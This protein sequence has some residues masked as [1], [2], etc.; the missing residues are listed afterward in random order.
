MS[1]IR[2]IWSPPSPGH[3]NGNWR[4]AW[5]PFRPTRVLLGWSGIRPF[6]P[7]VHV[8]ARSMLR[9]HYKNVKS[10]FGGNLRMVNLTALMIS[11]CLYSGSVL[12]APASSSRIKKWET[13]WPQKQDSL[14]ARA[15]LMYPQRFFMMDTHD[16]I[17]AIQFSSTFR[18]SDLTF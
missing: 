6:H 17:Q 3:D 11:T 16:S 10:I 9:Y 4:R 1:S 12:V 18:A 14:F 7:S 15:G 8:H 2:S 13:C 5:R